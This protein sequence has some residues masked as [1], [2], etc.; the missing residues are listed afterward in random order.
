MT[1]SKD[2]V[3]ALKAQLAA[4]LH[5][6]RENE[7]KMQRFQA[8]ELRLIGTRSLSALIQN[9]LYNYRTAFALDAVS[10]TLYDPQYEIHRM[11]EDEGTRVAEMTNL[12]FIR[13]RDSLDEMFGTSNQPKLLEYDK[14]AHRGLF[15]K[16]IPKLR[17]IAMLPLMRYY[18]IV[19]S[20][21]LGSIARERFSEESATDF[22]QRLSTIVAICLENTAN[23]ERLKRVGLTDSLT[24]IN[25][26]RFFDQRIGEEIARS[27]RTLEPI[28]CLFLDVDYFKQ[29]N[30]V[31]GHQVGDLAL[32]EIAMLI[33]E[34]LRNSDVL[35]RY[36]GEEFAAILT[37]STA[38]T[39]MEIAERIRFRIENHE[40]KLKDRSETLQLT[41]SIGISEL[42]SKT[43]PTDVDTL[44]QSLV[45]R[46][47]AALYAAKHRGRNCVVVAD[48][49]ELC[50]MDTE[51][52]QITGGTA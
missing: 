22:L 40:I 27:L 50:N 33:R 17:S 52:S 46:A 10:L 18:D 1:D 19:G 42:S 35:C 32:R 34:Q 44:T 24:G 21:N 4:F 12:I 47:D 9:I 28:A 15:S 48:G 16:N 2:E 30:D 41:I 11:L 7:Q 8:Q 49:V 43:I 3:Q 6:A 45:S 5:Q 39:A 23:H 51:N 37:N 26:R 13:E 25:N 29:V 31:H 36:G 20:L 38:A 14:D